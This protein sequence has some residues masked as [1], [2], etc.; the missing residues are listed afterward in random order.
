MKNDVIQYISTLINNSEYDLALRLLNEIPISNK[1][2]D[3]VIYLKSVCYINKNEPDYSEA[4]NN[5]NLL[6]SKV[7]NDELEY[8]KLLCKYQTNQFKDIIKYYIDVQNRHKEISSRCKFLI[9]NTYEKIEQKEFAKIIYEEIS[10]NESDPTIKSKSINNLTIIDNDYPRN[11]QRLQEAISSA[12][13]SDDSFQIS[14]NLAMCYIKNGNLYEGFNIFEE[15]YHKIKSDRNDSKNQIIFNYL[16]SLVN[17]ENYEKAESLLREL[18][19]DMFTLML[20]NV[21]IKQNKHLE[22]K[23]ILEKILSMSSNPQIIEIAK[24]VVTNV[25]TYIAANNSN[26]KDSMINNTD[27]Y[28]LVDLIKNTSEMDIPSD[29]SKQKVIEEEREESKRSDMV[30]GVYV[31]ELHNGFV[32]KDTDNMEEIRSSVEKAFPYNDENKDDLVGSIDELKVESIVDD[33]IKNV[34]QEI[35]DKL[36][37]KQISN[38]NEF[39]ATNNEIK[40]AENQSLVNDNAIAEIDEATN[41]EIKIAENQSVVNDN[42]IDEID[43]GN[44]VEEIKSLEIENVEEGNRDHYE[45]INDE[46]KPNEEEIKSIQE[47]SREML[48]NEVPINN[49]DLFDQY[50]NEKESKFLMDDI[51]ANVKRK[52]TEIE[53]MIVP[54]SNLSNN[55]LIEMTDQIKKDSICESPDIQPLYAFKTSLRKNKDND[56]DEIEEIQFKKHNSYEKERLSIKKDNKRSYTHLPNKK[57]TPSLSLRLMARNDDEY[58]S[59][60]YFYSFDS[61]NES[62]SM[63]NN[64]LN[65]SNLYKRIKGVKSNKAKKLNNTS[66]HQ[67][68][69]SLIDKMNMYDDKKKSHHKTTSYGLNSFSSIEKNKV[70]NDMVK[71]DVKSDFEIYFKK[72]TGASEIEFNPEALEQLYTKLQNLYGDSKFD[73]CREVIHKIRSIDKTYNEKELNIVMGKA[74]YEAKEYKKAIYEI[75]KNSATLNLENMLLLINCYKKVDKTG[76]YAKIILDYIRINEYNEEIYLELIDTLIYFSD[77]ELKTYC[78]NYIQKNE[79]TFQSSSTILRRLIA[80]SDLNDYIDELLTHLSYAKVTEEENAEYYYLYARYMLKKKNVNIAFDYFNKVGDDFLQEDFDFNKYFGKTC[81]MLKNYKKAI[82]LFKKALNVEKNDWE[83]SL[84]IGECYLKL[85]NYEGANKYLTYSSKKDNNGKNNLKLNL[86]LG[87]LYYKLKNYLLALDFFYKCINIDPKSFKTYHNISMIFLEKREFNEAEKMLE[88]AIAVNFD[89]FPALFELFKLR[90]LL[91]KESQCI[92]YIPKIEVLIDN[93]PMCYLDFS[94]ILAENFNDIDKSFKFFSL[95]LSKDKNIKN[96]F[97]LTKA[98][99][100]SDFIYKKGHKD[101]AIEL[102]SS[103]IKLNKYSYFIIKRLNAIYASMHNYDKIIANILKYFSVD[104]NNYEAVM[105]LAD[106]YSFTK[107]YGKAKEYY[108]EAIGIFNK[109]DDMLFTNAYKKIGYCETKLGLYEAAVEH[110]LQQFMHKEDMKLYAIICYIYLVYLRKKEYAD[111]YYKVILFQ[112]RKLIVLSIRILRRFIILI[113]IC[114]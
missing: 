63:G 104:K 13:D 50:T 59:N 112:F 43:E 44:S 66:L 26:F 88:K 37:N 108:D 61:D 99:D 23:H 72:K 101:K 109:K 6:L 38:I 60:C 22:A 40:I 14:N 94:K 105:D 85:E 57:F 64:N 46:L 95:A 54:K 58:I 34:V 71:D 51:Y 12:V 56:D 16:N 81:L 32:I 89:F 41:N 1:M 67:L 31:E 29:R 52:I 98:L 96:N 68:N 76:N 15:I 70:F 84:Y 106:T 53:S 107:D 87:R 100:Y 4:L 80:N 35:N 17:F 18:D 103:L 2:Q 82:K 91:K 5:I 10:I 45:F 55:N 49:I 39:D 7:T 111:I 65:K 113:L 27:N 110:F 47:N 30:T 78:E 73:E 19:D 90:C 114:Y 3:K 42:A 9:A 28:H 102:Y 36:N 83:M 24:D 86:S 8:M 11:I 79:Y 77:Y 93:Y 74:Y 92:E 21:N 48:V 97:N 75:E 62:V 20:A 25:N 69:D 33:N